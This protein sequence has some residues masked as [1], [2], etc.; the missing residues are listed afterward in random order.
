M[1]LTYP[2]ESPQNYIINFS[3]EWWV[4]DD[5]DHL[6]AGQ[7]LWAYVHHV[8]QVPMALIAQGRTKATEHHLAE[9]ALVRVDPKNIFQRSQIPVA[10]LPLIRSGLKMR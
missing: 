1:T 8:D 4:E 5:T 9:C 7:L 2:E 6:H 10:S 3:G